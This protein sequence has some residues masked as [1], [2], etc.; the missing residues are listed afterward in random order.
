V[1]DVMQVFVAELRDRAAARAASENTQIV[2][3]PL[4]IWLQYGRGRSS[5]RPRL[6]DTVQEKS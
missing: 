6:L 4:A 3:L 1:L 5:T 2:M